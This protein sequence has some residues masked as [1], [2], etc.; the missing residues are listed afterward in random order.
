M[1]ESQDQT[2]KDAE[3]PSIA[4]RDGVVRF[5]TT[6]VLHGVD[7][8]LHPGTIHAL[9]GQNGAGKTTLVKALIG[10]NELSEGS[11]EIAGSRRT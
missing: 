10:V 8:E 6:T 2:A 9:V 5:G 11:I 4:L 3:A 7:L 1:A